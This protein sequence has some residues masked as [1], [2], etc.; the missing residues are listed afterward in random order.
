MKGQELGGA[1][2]STAAFALANSQ[3]H[4][5][6]HVYLKDTCAPSKPRDDSKNLKKNRVP[7]AI[8][9]LSDPDR[10]TSERHL[11]TQ[12]LLHPP[13][14]CVKKKWVP[15]DAKYPAPETRQEGP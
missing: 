3:P 13:K 4:L 9:A 10:S 2:R 1:R 12:P 8:H 11:S 6:V 14:N 15:E 7:V 5:V